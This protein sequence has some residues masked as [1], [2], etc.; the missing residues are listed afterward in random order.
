MSDFFGGLVIGLVLA[1]MTGLNVNADI[2]EKELGFAIEK[3]KDNGGMKRYYFDVTGEAV[4]YC[5]NGAK[6]EYTRGKES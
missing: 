1:L 6:F 3:C 2:D 4:A 5:N